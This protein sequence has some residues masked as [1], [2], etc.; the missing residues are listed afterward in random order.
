MPGRISPNPAA[1]AVLLAALLVVLGLA[2]KQLVTLLIAVMIAVII[3]IGLSGIAG[4][5]ERVGVPRGIGILL[6]LLAGISVLIGLGALVVPTFVDQVNAIVND[7]PTI[8]NSVGDSIHKLTGSRPAGVGKNFQHFVQGYTRNP[9]KLLGTLASIGQSVAGAVAALV[10]I[11]LTAV[12]IAVNPEPLV[13]GLVRLVPPP[14]RVRATTVL[15]RIRTAWIGWMAGLG[16][17]M[18]VLGSIFY[19]GLLLVGIKFA[20][21]FAVLSAVSVVVPYF[22]ALASGI[23]P[24][25][26]ALSYSPGKALAVLGVYLVAHQVEGN[27]IGP[28]VMARAVRLHAA[29]IAVGVVIIEQL[30]GPFGL[31]IAVP[32]IAAVVIFVEEVWVKPMEAEG[33]GVIELP[34]GTEP[35]EPAR[36]VEVPITSRV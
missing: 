34:V 27:L 31:I 8:Y 24:I 25:L 10:L 11:V 7:L 4:R 18:L 5:L 2:F 35:P 15:D 19:V 20:L 21:A 1:R 12:F 33:P 6:G 13:S 3:A 9:Q 28:L 16:V 26:F 30:L 23:P 36:H 32:L 29:L 17:S 14:Y 22:G